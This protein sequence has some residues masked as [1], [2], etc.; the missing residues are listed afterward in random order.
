[1]S[2]L[3]FLCSNKHD[4]A[5]FCPGDTVGNLEHRI[6]RVFRRYVDPI[7]LFSLVLSVTACD[8]DPKGYQEEAARSSEQL[9]RETQEAYQ[10]L[11][12]YALQKQKE[13]RQQTEA[14]LARY[15]E[16]IEKLR[17][18]IEK[19][20]T[21]ARREC[22]EIMKEWHTRTENL[23]Q[24]LEEIKSTGAEAWQQAE[25]QIN[26]G[27]EELGKLYERAR[28]TLGGLTLTPRNERKENPRE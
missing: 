26:A 17:E 27:M 24:Q 6:R 15:E 14:K 22:N 28:S 19:A 11:K 18:K 25:R 21:E 12:N 8:K 16:R 1:M 5:G 20:G 13:F 23:R 4:Q 2:T 10:A 3:I 7:V 9:V